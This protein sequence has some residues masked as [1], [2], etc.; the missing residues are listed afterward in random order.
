MRSFSPES[1]AT[2]EV[3]RA[4]GRAGPETLGRDHSTASR[5]SAVR[6]ATSTNDADEASAVRGATPT[7][8]HEKDVG[9]LQPIAA[10]VL[11]KILYAAR[12]ARFDL[13]RAVCRLLLA[14]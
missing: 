6:G 13:L 9:A 5:R 11:M 4:G 10:K 3:S 12:M 7:E 14:L 1:C 8:H 2:S